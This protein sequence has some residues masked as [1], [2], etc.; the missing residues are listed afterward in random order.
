MNI[1]K[2]LD[3]ITDCN[4]PPRYDVPTEDS[5]NGSL[6]RLAAVPIAFSTDL[7]MCMAVSAESSR[8]THPGHCA[9][10]VDLL[11]SIP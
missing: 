7:A 8:T 2:S 1:G 9:A 3:A 6:M 11:F 5:G 10:E 4:P